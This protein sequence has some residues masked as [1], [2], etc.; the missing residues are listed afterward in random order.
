MEEEGSRQEPRDH[1]EASRKGVEQHRDLRGDL[2]LTLGNT[3]WQEEHQHPHAPWQG[4]AWKCP[5][6]RNIGVQVG[7][8]TAGFRAQHRH[9]SSCVHPPPPHLFP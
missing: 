5:A 6:S 7:L 3:E 2:K 9:N 8:S 1:Q 4:R